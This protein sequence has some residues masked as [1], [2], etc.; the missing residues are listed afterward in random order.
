M[1]QAIVDESDAL[2]QF[3]QGIMSQTQR[4]TIDRS[5]QERYNIEPRQFY[6]LPDELQREYYGQAAQVLDIIEPTSDF[7]RVRSIGR[8]R[9]IYDEYTR[10]PRQ[11]LEVRGVDPEGAPFAVQET[12]ADLP[13]GVDQ[14]Q[15]ANRALSEQFP[16]VSI[17]DLDVSLEPETNNV[18]FK[19]PE[20][21]QYTTINPV[22][23]NWMDAAGRWMKLEGDA[24]MWS[25]IPGVLA[26]VGTG[27][28]TKSPGLAQT[29]GVIADVGGYFE[30]RR[31]TLKDLKE[32]GYLDENEWTDGAIIRQSLMD[33][34]PVG[35][36]SVA[37][38]ALTRLLTA[39]IK[40]LPDMSLDE[41]QLVKAIKEVYASKGMPFYDEKSAVQYLYQKQLAGELPPNMRGG[42]VPWEAYS[43][44]EILD[45]ARRVADI[46]NPGASIRPTTPQIIL[47]ASE[48]LGINIGGAPRKTAETLQA[49]LEAIRKEGGPLAQQVDEIMSGQEAQMAQKYQMLLDQGLGTEDALRQL[50]G[51]NTKKITGTATDLN[52]ILSEPQIARVNE[53]TNEIQRLTDEAIDS[54]D[55][56]TTNRLTKQE[57]GASTR[58][59]FEE[60][61][62]AGEKYIDAFYDKLG[63]D[64]GG[65]RAI[66]DPTSLIEKVKGLETG[67]GR[68]IIQSFR[69]DTNALDDILKLPKLKKVTDGR[70]YKNI[71]YE[72]IKGMIEDING[73]L[74]ENLSTSEKRV[75]T[76]LKDTLLDFRSSALATQGDD[77]A[78]MARIIDEGYSTFK[79]T[80]KTG[81]IN[82]IT[83]ARSGRYT[84]GEGSVM[85]AL[86]LQ[87]TKKDKEF[88]KNIINGNTPG[89][90]VAKT[91]VQSWLRGEL[92]SL[93][94]QA[95]GSIDPSRITD[96]QLNGFLNKYATLLDDYLPAK[97]VSRI[98]K[99]PNLIN[100]M[101][102]G[103]KEQERLLATLKSDPELG[104][105][106][107]D[108]GRAQLHNDPSQ[109][110]TRLYGRGP[111]VPGGKTR[112]AVNV[113]ALQKTVRILKGRNDATSRRVLED[114]KM[115]AA[116]DLD[117]EVSL[118]SKSVNGLI[119]PLEFKEY[120]TTMEEPLEILFGKKFVKG[121]GDYER[122]IR[123]L[124]PKGVGSGAG[125]E[126]FQ[127]ALK[128][129]EADALK[130][131]TD[132][133]R[134]YIGIFTRPGRFLTALLRQVST[135]QQKRLTDLMLN[136]DKITSEY[137]AKQFFGNPFVQMLARQWPTFV[138]GPK[139]PGDER[140]SSEK[141]EEDIEQMKPQLIEEKRITFFNSGGSVKL[142]P[143][144]Y[145][146]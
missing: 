27:A 76:Q 14:L 66:Y 15:A 124:M 13:A 43:T 118:G 30:F 42:D 57:A 90:D 48:E 108:M 100:D 107:D 71:S 135:K 87:G 115:Y 141:L 8:V 38:V 34:I 29:A 143:L 95:D 111:L 106:F 104:T 123:Y 35:I 4:E 130:V 64:A 144:E 116:K 33:S 91:N 68:R 145:D 5:L 109:V 110:F 98:R 60:Q 85:D 54:I 52:K 99:L 16:G 32:R 62:E 101:T 69:K 126:A 137:A 81:V 20:T 131:G 24:I 47:E 113:P 121:L 93:G 2:Q 138:S 146:L 80:F 70:Q 59:F 36:G 114:L 19:N 105:I 11:E 23:N 28:L 26:G 12:L 82:K 86:L 125:A 63:V 6:S 88:V 79:D 10:T 132:V 122:M 41:Q 18:I 58:E 55:N 51:I 67:E 120:L 21:Q 56:L 94:R 31:R 140:G 127:Q 78:Q 102:R 83:K 103:I 128:Q 50:A 1:Q 112:V 97:E 74:Q 96:A 25:L 7:D 75:Y 40:R 77:V 136:P 39:H 142:I 129:A 65:G 49:A 134:A 61:I 44:D 9:D 84:T 119:N 17:Q 22:G 133:T 46:E 117:D 139:A 73:K 37:G 45:M 92:Y 3:Q 72:Q 53:A 89:A